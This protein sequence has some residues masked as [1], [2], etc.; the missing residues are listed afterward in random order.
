MWPGGPGPNGSSGQ[1]ARSSPK[2]SPLGPCFGFGVTSAM[3]LRDVEGEEE[4][5]EYDSQNEER[6]PVR[7]EHEVLDLLEEGKCCTLLKSDRFLV[8]V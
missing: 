1:A 7:H 3:S 8:S 5:F 6:K 4:C 2:D